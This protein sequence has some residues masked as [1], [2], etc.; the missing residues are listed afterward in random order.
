MKTNDGIGYTE[1]LKSIIN[2][3]DANVHCN[4]VWENS[5]VSQRF[6]YD[7]KPKR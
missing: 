5:V 6:I 2:A 7:A 4:S 1:I 3:K